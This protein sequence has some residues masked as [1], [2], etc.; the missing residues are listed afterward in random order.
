MGQLHFNAQS[1]A[2]DDRTLAHVK[3]AITI[4]LR[5]QENFFLSW[6]KPA[7][8]GGGRISLWMSPANPVA[9][10]FGEGRA[11]ALNATWIR[12]MESV[13]HS[14]LGMIVV[15]EEESQAYAAKHFGA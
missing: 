5:R 8:Q 1:Y 13:S 2:F 6:T 4:R 9:F 7:D 12:V 10:T 14:R 11:P 3:A 15:T